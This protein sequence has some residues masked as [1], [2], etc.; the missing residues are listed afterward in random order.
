[1]KTTT[2]QL[3]ILTIKPNH[4]YTLLGF[5][6]GINPPYDPGGMYTRGKNVTHK[7]NKQQLLQTIADNVRKK[8]PWKI[9]QDRYIT[10]FGELPREYLNERLAYDNLLEKSKNY[11]LLHLVL[12]EVKVEVRLNLDQCIAWEISR[13]EEAA[14]HNIVPNDIKKILKDINS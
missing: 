7:M 5:T 14:A 12:S 4:E 6:A 13:W 2:K 1:M 8:H 11:K 10:L 9:S 3:K